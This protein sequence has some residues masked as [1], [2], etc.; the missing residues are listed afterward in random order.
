[1]STADKLNALVQTKADI[2]QALIDKGQN[3]SDVFSTYA[4]DIRAIETGGG[5]RD[6]SLLG[7]A[8]EPDLF[9]DGF[10]YAISLKQ[11]LEN[12]TGASG[13]I[14]NDLSSNP[15]L[16]YLPNLDWVKVYMNYSGSKGE[17]LVRNPNLEYIDVLDF[18][19]PF[20]LNNELKYVPTSNLCME[21]PK[22]K[23]VKL[24]ILPDLE[25]G[26]SLYNTFQNCKSL[27]DI[28]IT[29]G[30]V[31]DL[32]S[33]FSY[34]SINKVP[35][36]DTSICTTMLSCFSNSTIQEADL[37]DWD[38]SNVETLRNLFFSA[39]SLKKVDFTGFNAPKCTQFDQMFFDCS[40]LEELII[41]EGFGK[42][43]TNFYSMFK[44][45]SKLPVEQIN[46]MDT[47][48]GTEF[49]TMFQYFTNNET[50]LDLSWLN[51][52][53]AT[54]LHSLVYGC[55]S[56]KCLNL[57]GLNTRN[58]NI[59]SLVYNCSG[60]IKIDGELS[61]YSTDTSNY[62]WLVG[63]SAQSNLRHVTI[64]DIGEQGTIKFNMQNLSNW[65]VED[66]TIELSIGAKK[67]M[68]DTLIT[69]SYDRVNN[70]L[71]STNIILSAN[72]KALLTEEEIAQITA[73]GYTIA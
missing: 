17:A 48:S 3:P 70:G 5:G 28:N 61:V 60:L 23:M 35:E 73:K 13:N 4:D 58:A 32:N 49:S 52:D 7:Y 24:M 39:K 69:Y 9:E 59:G 66:E 1:M 53:N 22:L 30:K 18:S 8:E 31:N 20:T 6:W 47:S 65:G 57:S 37:T 16:I 51:I 36:L 46:K 50:E 62:Y 43:V 38:F 67:S 33:T 63:Y 19:R 64:K 56:L 14:L 12:N 41:P 27:K 55:S 15:K 10:N 26:V 40:N 2:K 54:S 42:G 21:S 68:T 11:K 29:G 72:T 44:S 45:C 34:T 25:E 71:S